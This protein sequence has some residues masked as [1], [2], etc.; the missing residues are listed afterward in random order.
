MARPRKQGLDYFPLDV[1]FF[2]DDR[3]LVV[4]ADFGFKG[5]LAAIKLLCM[6]YA[7]GYYISWSELVQ[8]KLIHE[9]KG[10]A[11]YILDMIVKRL[12]KVGFFNKELFESKQILTSIEIQRRYFEATK[13]RKIEAKDLPYLLVP[14]T[15]YS[16]LNEVQARPQAATLPQPKPAV[17]PIPRN[18]NRKYVA[19]HNFWKKFF[20][21]SNAVSINNVCAEMSIT[22]DVFVEYAMAVL[23]EW[24]IAEKT[25]KDYTDAAANLISHVRRKATDS[26]S[27][28]KKRR[29]E[30][31]IDAQAAQ[32]ALRE[33][34]RKVCNSSTAIPEPSVSWESYASRRGIDPSKEDA[35]T[36]AARTAAEESAY[37]STLFGE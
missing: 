13:G 26:T 29:N 27:D 7:N 16:I 18:C 8:A 19:R 9:L 32:R 37:I 17:S 30:T 33:Q 31:Q 4:S 20:D 2:E 35:G 34:S 12:V 25:H 6:I 28:S 15:N 21:K 36:F 3:L 14:P 23:N 5:E 24:Q 11:S 22:Y 1:D 10:I